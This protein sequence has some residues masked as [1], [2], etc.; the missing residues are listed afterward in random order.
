ML[1]KQGAG[2][3]DVCGS[4]ARVRLLLK[5]ASLKLKL[6]LTKIKNRIPYIHTKKYIVFNMHELTLRMQGRFRWFK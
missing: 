1:A 6:S 2:P 4:E 5:T 3:G